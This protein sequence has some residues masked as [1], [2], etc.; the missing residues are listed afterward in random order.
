MITTMAVVEVGSDQEV[1]LAWVHLNFLSTF[2][3]CSR[4]FSWYQGWLKF[5]NIHS[6]QPAPVFS[7]KQQNNNHIC[8]LIAIKLALV[9]FAIRLLGNSNK[10]SVG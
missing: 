9:T 5:N 8:S 1:E 3:I 7:T 6:Q 10:S 4:I 2:N